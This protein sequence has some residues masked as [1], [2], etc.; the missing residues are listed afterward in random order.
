L[1][2]IYTVFKTM[3]NILILGYGQLGHT[4]CKR[5]LKLGQR[6]ITVSRQLHNSLAAQHQH[7]SCD[8][9]SLAK[10][11]IA[12]N[13]AESIDGL[14]Y[15]APPTASGTTDQRLQHFL[16]SHSHLHIKHLVYISTTGVYGDSQG[17][18]ITES[19]AVSPSADRAQ[20]R[21]DAEQQLTHYALQ[22]N[23]ALTILRCAAIYS[24]KTV[25]K[26][27]ITSNNKPVIRADQAPF[28]NRIHLTD[29]TEVC[30]KAMLNPPSETQ[31]YNVSDGH[32]S[33]TTEHAWLMSDLAG[34]ER[35]REIDLEDAAQYY[36]PAYLSYLHESKRLDTTKLVSQLSPEFLFEDCQLG[37]LQCLKHSD[38]NN[39]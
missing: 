3:T 5:H 24:S 11:D 23:T 18:W 27:R 4:I 35:N 20:R 38:E 8:L 21:L 31:I 1:S 33:T 19:T 16:S 28:T 13:F 17:Q 12:D 26:E 36:S 10:L 15:L 2:L 6:V 22:T 29:L 39:S 14:Y 7:L 9:D 30:I 25:N 37:L 32:P 34:V